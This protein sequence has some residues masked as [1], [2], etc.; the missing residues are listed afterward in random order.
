MLVLSEFA[1]LAGAGC[2][3]IV[4]CHPHSEVFQGHSTQSDN[5]LLAS[6]K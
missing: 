4:V 6:P 5:I 2:I 3:N 1:M